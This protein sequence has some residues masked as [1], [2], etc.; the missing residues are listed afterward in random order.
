M[1]FTKRWE[2]FNTNRRLP[3]PAAI[4]AVETID[5][6]YGAEVDG[7]DGLRFRI[8]SFIK[9]QFSLRNGVVRALGLFQ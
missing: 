9:W 6:N 8:W 2:I 4:T 3:C 1:K 7:D 5:S